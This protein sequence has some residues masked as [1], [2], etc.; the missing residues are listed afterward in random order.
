MNYNRIGR[1]VTFA[2]TAAVLMLVTLVLIALLG[3]RLLNVVNVIAVLMLIIVL[4]I[5]T[6]MVLR[7]SFH[8]V[9]PY[10]RLVVFR[11]GRFARVVNPGIALLL[12]LVELGAVVDMRDREQ[13]FAAIATT[14]DHILV[15][16]DVTLGFRVVDPAKR[17]LGA[18]DID[19]L[20]DDAMPV[21]WESII[22]DKLARDIMDTQRTMEGE[23][24]TR[25]GEIIEYA[26]ISIIDLQI[27]G[28]KKH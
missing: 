10:Q 24:Q 22:K 25:L 19:A 3:E 2:L 26:G 7:A 23:L 4:G 11:L 12:P 13:S 8:I 17:V 18:A 5:V 20:L 21:A 9:L 16:I 28:I 1:L 15:S 27:N 6:D 14:N